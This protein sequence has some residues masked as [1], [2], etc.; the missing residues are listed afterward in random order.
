MKV[1]IFIYLFVFVYIYIYMYIFIFIYICSCNFIY[2]YCL[3]IY[4]YKYKYIYIFM[5]LYIYEF[6]NSLIYCNGFW[7]MDIKYIYI[8]TCCRTQT[9]LL[10]HMF[11]HMSFEIIL[12]MNFGLP[13]PL[14]TAFELTNLKTCVKCYARCGY[15]N[16]T[17]PYSR[18][19]KYLFELF[20]LSQAFKI[21]TLPY[22]IRGC[23]TIIVCN[24]YIKHKDHS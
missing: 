2:Y 11:L 18:T 7:I 1:N 24:K 15:T 16:A 12:H 21:S 19:S 10:S 8:Y 20:Q 5:Y 14:R 22:H 3:Y 6:I 4:K 23:P 9:Y 17:G 13:G